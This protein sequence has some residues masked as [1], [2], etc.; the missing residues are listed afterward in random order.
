MKERLALVQQNASLPAAET[1]AIVFI[2]IGVV[3]LIGIPISGIFFC[4]CRLCGKCGAKR[5]HRPSKCVL[6]T[7]L[8]ILLIGTAFV[9]ALMGVY[10]VAVDDTAENVDELGNITTSIG[11]DLGNVLTTASGNITCELNDVFGVFFDDMSAIISDIPEET[12][13]E[14]ENKYGYNE[15]KSILSK[16][17]EI[18]RKFL[19]ANISVSNA[20]TKLNDL[21]SKSWSDE[22]ELQRILHEV[23]FIHTSLSEVN[24]HFSDIYKQLST[25]FDDVDKIINGSKAQVANSI[26]EAQKSLDKAES[27]VQGISEKIDTTVDEINTQISNLTE[28]IQKIQEDIDES[29]IKTGAFHGLRALVLVP[30]VLVAVSSLVALIFGLCRLPLSLS[31]VGGYG[32]EMVCK[33]LFDDP[34]M[35]LLNRIPTFKFEVP[36]IYDS[37]SATI[38]AFDEVLMQCNEHSSIFTA[39]S[40]DAIMNVS[41]ILQQANLEEY[42]KEAIDAFRKQSFNYTIDDSYSNLLDNATSGLQAAMGN[43]EVTL[44]ATTAAAGNDSIKIAQVED[45][46][47][48]LREMK[49]L[50][51]DLIDAMNT[52]LNDVKHVITLALKSGNF[53][54]EGI[55]MITHIFDETIENVTEKVYAAKERLLMNTFDCYPLYEVWQTVGFT[56]CDRVGKPLQGM[57]ASA[58]LAA[59]FIVV[60]IVALILVAKYLQGVDP[61]YDRSAAKHAQSRRY[62]RTDEKQQRPITTITTAG[63][64]YATYSSLDSYAYNGYPSYG[65]PISIRY[66]QP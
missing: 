30:C 14:F 44:N 46:E 60:L 15:I 4:S 13:S 62:T 3:I 41:A 66:Q 20:T 52:T 38:I 11:T 57:W 51:D 56:V 27:D 36:P 2:A 45:G 17:E 50:V 31:F 35:R 63:R 47:G 42:K 29:P 6:C 9:A 16:N 26:E 28:N 43:F 58:G 37:D 18:S 23:G 12:F 25:T 55:E 48:A 8:L 49:S 33:P 1:G 22:N 32:V 64:L 59:I 65:K 21:M 53:T 61:K 39:L 34:Q 54:D 24:M 10:V 5:K 40:G 19:Y 7:G